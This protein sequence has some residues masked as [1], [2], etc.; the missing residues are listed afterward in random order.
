VRGQKFESANPQAALLIVIDRFNQRFPR[1]EMAV[2]R[3]NPHPCLLG[4]LL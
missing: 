4:N 2:E 3:T 1:W